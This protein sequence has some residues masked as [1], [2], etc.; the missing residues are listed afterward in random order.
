MVTFAHAGFLLLAP[1]LLLVV[2]A[3]WRRSAQTLSRGRRAASL[4]ARAVAIALLTAAMSRPLLTLR[5]DLPYLTVFLLDVSESVPAEAWKEPLERVRR[6]W[7]REISAGNRCALV[8]FA[9]RAAVLAPPG[10]GPLSIDAD[11]IAH[12]AA[13]ERLAAGDRADTA[14]IVDLDRWTE[15]LDVTSTDLSRGLE[16]ARA[17]FSDD[18]EN[19][20]VL[21]TDGRDT[22]RPD[23]LLPE[24]TALIRLEGPRK[25]VAVVDVSAPL[26]VRMG[27]PFDVRVTL[28]APEE[29]SLALTLSVNGASVS[30]AA[31]G[32]LEGAGGE[33][34]DLKAQAL[35]YEARESFLN[36]SFIAL[37]QAAAWRDELI[38]LARALD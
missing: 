9:G 22:T 30:E 13:R 28:N 2:I 10:T 29:T 14:R 11:R 35:T 24:G 8:A 32:V 31:Q 19:R 4:A 38:Q 17:L 33:V 26:A 7:D 34:L 37:P 27:E 20:I 1:A 12:R 23:P 15:S 5:S 21:V 6:A 18:A 25:D 3:P 36:P 16:T